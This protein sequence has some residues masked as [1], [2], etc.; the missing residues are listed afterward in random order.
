MVYGEKRMKLILNNIKMP[1]EHTDEMIME[2]SKTYFEKCGIKIDELNIYRKSVDAR[3]KNN[4]HYIC[5]V[6]AKT[7]SSAEEIEKLRDGNIKVYN[8]QKIDFSA[9]K[10]KKREKVVIIG[11]GPCG[12]FSAYFLAKAGY[13]PIVCE[14]GA[15]V[16]KRTEE[17]R[18][19]WKSGILNKNT[20]VQF[21]EGGA[22]TFSDG[23]LTCRIGDVL[24][25]NVLEIFVEHGAS[26]DILYKAKP[27][28]GTDVLKN[29]VKNIRREIIRLGGVVKFNAKL[30]DIKTEK[31]RIC[32]AV[33]NDNE[34][35]TCDRLILAV[36]HSARDTYEMLFNKGV[37]LE[38]KA[39]AAG[40][41]IEHTQEFINK[42][43]YKGMYSNPNLPVADYRLTYNGRE[44]SC[45]TFCMCPGG[46]VVNASSEEEALCIN[47]M[48]EYSRNGKNANSALVVNVRPSDFE[49]PLPLSGIEFQRKWERAAYK[50][51]GGKAP[52]QL[53][54]DFVK[55]R[56]SD[57][58]G[59][60]FPSFT[61]KT[62]FSDLRECLPNF[63]SETLCE[64]LLEFERKIKFYTS[65]D[66]VLSGVEMR[67]S[68]PIRIMRNSEFESVSIKG[69]YPAGEG[70]GYAGGIMSAAVDGIK[71][72]M[73][74]VQI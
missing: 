40:V 44:R 66:A 53:A 54:R 2:Y 62:E 38:S 4:I 14:R 21:G 61:G 10:R 19:F 70:A 30:T 20:N 17:V 47:G 57:S 69:L 6:T 29:V 37:I 52:I 46:T 16:D 32:S 58:I 26:K 24:Q 33:I 22:G 27:H 68:A 25:R 13:C 5:A 9:I 41:R 73:K 7:D 35:I 3:R 15:D 71:I 36:G 59:E 39:F 72:A 1:V 74:I 56:V 48:S 51:N 31:G 50:L 65:G 34:E 18:E 23:K 63:I 55:N 12:L 64:A 28:I 43:Q 49:T 42:T 67:T 60:V 45:Y 11:T 8:E